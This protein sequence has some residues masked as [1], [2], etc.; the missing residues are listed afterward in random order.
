MTRLR[1]S[2]R[3]VV[4]VLTATT[5]A[6][7]AACAAS[8][9]EGEGTG[10]QSPPTAAAEVDFSEGLD[11]T[12]ADGRYDD[13]RA[14]LVDV[15]GERVYERY[16][17]SS[18]EETA[19]VR[20][21]TAS[22]L[23]ILVGVALERGELDS[24]DQTVGELLPDHADAMTAGVPGVTLRELMTMTSGL[25]SIEEEPAEVRADPLPWALAHEEA[26]TGGAA[27]AYSDAAAHLVS[28]ILERATG[29]PVLD[30]AREALFD[31]LGIETAEAA[32][33]VTGHRAYA[34]VYGKAGFAWP[35]DPEGHHRGDSYV[36]LTAEDMAS[37]GRLMLE[38]GAWDGEQLVPAE[39]VEE[40]TTQQADV[41]DFYA[42][43]IEGFGYQWWLSSAGGH[44]TFAA[45]GEGGQVI[46]VV[47]DLDL[48]VVV[49]TRIGDVQWVQ[50][51]VFMVMVD[52][53]IA[54]A[55][56]G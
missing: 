49:S 47:P 50:P 48:V 40:S 4:A 9:P 32:E 36:K 34:K 20:G 7:G 23:S 25:P 28:P 16:F 52:G 45:G 10:E 30:Y 44:P 18:P 14:V 13:V 6:L 43:N 27:F 15:D 11:L 8:T 19:D 42:S 53:F 26:G 24:L 17:D 31:P 54:P 55:L 1:R 38:G 51:G 56:T 5:L 2:V 33:P 41:G 39:W 3:P 12:L 35:V 22:I 46:Q 21:V 37:I 29:R